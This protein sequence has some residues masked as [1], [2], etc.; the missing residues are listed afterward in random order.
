MP[1][2][3]RWRRQPAP[4][5]LGEAEGG[6]FGS[7]VLK[8]VP[9]AFTGKDTTYRAMRLM[10]KDVRDRTWQTPVEMGLAISLLA[11]I[12]DLERVLG[13]RGP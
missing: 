2:W 11:V 6:D 5:E 3:Q 10:A 4:M 8:G 12:D 1:G 9:D 13:E 7:R